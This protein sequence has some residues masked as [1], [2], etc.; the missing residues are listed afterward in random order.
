MRT[1]KNVSVFS[2]NSGVCFHLIMKQAILSGTKSKSTG[3]A[4]IILTKQLER[5]MCL[6]SLYKSDPDTSF[7][8]TTQLLDSGQSC[9]SHALTWIP[10]RLPSKRTVER[11]HPQVGSQLQYDLSV[12]FFFLFKILLLGVKYFSLGLFSYSC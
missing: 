5:K 12:H 4:V 2:K 1:F 6:Q 9:T 8:F 11:D 7:I 3:F 10:A